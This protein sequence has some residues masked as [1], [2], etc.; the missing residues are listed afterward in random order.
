MPLDELLRP[1]RAI[2]WAGLRS[3]SGNFAEKSVELVAFLRRFFVM[4]FGMN[5]LAKEGR[6]V[7]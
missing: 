5:R 2:F 3:I 6:G 4:P 1:S 7:R